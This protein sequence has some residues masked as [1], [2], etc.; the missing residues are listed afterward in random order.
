[1]GPQNHDIEGAVEAWSF[2]SQ[3]SRD[4]SAEPATPPGSLKMRSD[5]DAQRDASGTGQLFE[6]IHVPPLTDFAQGSNGIAIADLNRDGW[7]DLVTVTTPPLK[8]GLNDSLVRDRLRFLINRGGFEFESQAIELGGS[9]ATP[10]DLGQGWRGSQIPALADFNDDGFLDLFVSRQCPCEGGK[11]RDGFTAVGNSL[12]LSDGAFDRFVDRSEA[13]GVLN[14]MAYNR[15]PSIGDVDQD[16]FLDIAVGADNTTNAFEG[17]SQS[18]LFMFEPGDQGFRTVVTWIS[19]APSEFPTTAASPATPPRTPPDPT[20]CCATW[21]TTAIW[22]CCSRLTCFW[23]HRRSM[24][25]YCPIRRCAIAR[26]CSRGAT[27]S[28]RRA[29]SISS[30]RAKTASR[31]KHASHSTKTRDST[32]RPATIARPGWPICSPPTSTTMDCST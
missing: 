7:L 1:V 27:S 32:F 6:S 15:Q 10:E 13:L 8:L 26:A 24:R 30:N 16:G 4:E 12:F 28:P 22:I 11:V 3:F 21:T 20:S 17:F 29:C 14:E 2:L 31:P 5:T 18:A 19:A 23:A 9:P 25:G